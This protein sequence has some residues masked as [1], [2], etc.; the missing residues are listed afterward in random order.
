MKKKMLLGLCLIASIGTLG[1]TK[2]ENMKLSLNKTD[3]NSVLDGGTNSEEWIEVAETESL[4]E[5]LVE[6]EPEELTSEE[7]GTEAIESELETEAIEEEQKP[8]NL[9]DEV[10]NWDENW[11]YADHSLIHTDSVTLYRSHAAERKNLVITVNAGH[12]T[13]GGTKVK[14][15]CHP[16]GSP[17]VTGGSTPKGALKAISVSA[18]TEMLDGTEEGAV[19]VTLAVLLKEELLNAGFDVLMIRESADVQLDN[20][21]RTV[22]ANNNS[23]CHIALHYNATD[24]GEGL[25]CIGVPD[26]EEYKQMEPVASHWQQHN[27]LAQ[28]I[29]NGA[30]QENV[31]IWSNGF[32]G[33]DLTQTSYSTVPSTD[34]EVGDRASDYSKETQQ[35]I[36]EGIAAGVVLWA[37]EFKAAQQ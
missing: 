4:P 6:V 13:I 14:T 28:A 36:A 1:C 2:T 19:T 11:L 26:V 31:K 25:F 33:M 37:E 7:F 8:I 16:D 18:G 17:K 21:A 20:V 32:M 10:I 29:I 24:T 27:A 35:H 3:K 30:V 34:I 15:L 5:A 12:G 22:M 9:E 23:D